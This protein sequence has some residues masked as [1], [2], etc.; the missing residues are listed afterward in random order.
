MQPCCI[1]LCY[2]CGHVDA[3]SRD[4]YCN[5]VVEQ[6]YLAVFGSELFVV[7][8]G[9][10]DPKSIVIIVMITIDEMN[11]GAADLITEGERF[12]TWNLEVET[13]HNPEFVIFFDRGIDVFDQCT[14]RFVNRAEG[15]IDGRNHVGMT[16][17]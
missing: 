5:R 9:A 16:K 2:G 1:L 7:L 6:N 12:F 10:K 4:A 14:V 8:R 17:V 15:A 11:V 3:L 13:S